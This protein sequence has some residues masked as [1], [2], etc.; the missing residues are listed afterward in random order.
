MGGAVV[1]GGE[2]PPSLPQKRREWDG[3]LREAGNGSRAGP[4]VKQGTGLD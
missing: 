2:P 1:A 3:S 4:C